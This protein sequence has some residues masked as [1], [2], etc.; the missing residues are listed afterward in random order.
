MRF[1]KHRE[2]RIPRPRRLTM[3]DIRL[4]TAEE[5]KLL[6]QGGKTNTIKTLRLRIKHLRKDLK[7]PDIYPAV[8]STIKKELRQKEMQLRQFVE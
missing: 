5:R 7:D 4:I 8:R 6:K 3:E 1:P 2:L